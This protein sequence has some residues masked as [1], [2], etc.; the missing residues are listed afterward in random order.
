MGVLTSL[1]DGG[2]AFLD[3][4]ES[5]TALG[6]SRFP[7]VIDA[8]SKGEDFIAGIRVGG[9][10]GETL[11]SG[12]G[13]TLRDL[14]DRRVSLSLIGAFM[15]DLAETMERTAPGSVRYGADVAGLRRE[16]D[17][18]W[19]SVARDGSPLVTSDCV[20][21]ATGG[22]E[23]IRATAA[24]HGV[25]A[26]RM[27]GSAQLLRGDFDAVAEVL[28]KDGT[29][30]ILG[31]SHSGFA[32]A[33]LLLK[34][35]G[36]SISRNGLALIHRGLALSYENLGEARSARADHAQRH[37]VCPESGKVNR[38]HG[39]RAGPR[40][41]CL[42]ALRGHEPRLRLYESGSPS[43][44]GLLARADLLVHA[45]GYRPRH[46]PLFGHDG[47]PIWLGVRAGAV[48]DRCRLVDTRHKPV[49]G[50]F[51]LGLGYAQSDAWGRRRVGVN[52][53]HGPDSEHIVSQ[54][55]HTTSL[56]AAVGTT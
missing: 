42:R 52:T 50:V 49:P 28:R 3:R 1:L 10:F 44:Y 24:R 39:L 25:P 53:F 11:D 48:D 45:T 20:V 23:D 47:R 30:V 43:A 40:A 7:Y 2:I 38:F 5:S 29:A 8:N 27:V 46:V 32:T 14:R 19:T 17:G 41:L 55:L 4:A 36:D 13:R 35:F 21:L 6:N 31:G 54:V 51:G 12:A 37:E 34:R 26:E 22:H 33:E 16:S 18:T 15:N 56:S 9:V